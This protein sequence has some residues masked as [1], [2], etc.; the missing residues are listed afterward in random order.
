MIKNFDDIQKLSQ[1]N[2]DFG[3]KMMGD[4]SKGWQAIAAE[5]SDYTKRS[6]EEGSATMEK[7][8]S[9]KS[10]EQAIEIQSSYAK[11]AYEAWMQQ[12]NRVSGMYSNLAREAFKPAEKFMQA[13]R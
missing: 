12:M 10:L 3:V 6:F 1:S 2:L 7:L 8:T 11:H 13:A 5:M 4:W 9:A